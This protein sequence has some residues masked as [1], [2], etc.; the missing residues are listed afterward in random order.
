M[1]QDGTAE[2]IVRAAAAFDA[3]VTGCLAL[4]PTGRAF[5]R[6]L[7]ALEAFFGGSG[8][9]ALDPLAWFFVHLSGVLGVLWAWVR[10]RRPTRA[11]ASADV[12]GRC[13]V[14]GLLALAVAEGA[15]R[16][17]VAFMAT[18]LLGAIAQGRV[19]HAL[20]DG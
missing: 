18:E 6:T 2:R 16:V 17:L 1:P 20:S 12:V 10:W 11:H 3:L 19:R 15:P 5:V 13:A 4:P 8:P 9:A 14:A 7:T